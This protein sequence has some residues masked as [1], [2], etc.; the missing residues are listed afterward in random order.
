[1]IIRRISP[2]FVQKPQVIGYAFDQFLF[3]PIYP[4]Q[5]LSLLVLEIRF[6]ASCESRSSI[7]S[8]GG[9]WSGT[10]TWSPDG[11]VTHLTGS[12]GKGRKRSSQ[13]GG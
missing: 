12:G 4:A 10:A 3:C 1:V 2:I 11:S 13:N 7:R 9:G 5:P 6:V 8:S